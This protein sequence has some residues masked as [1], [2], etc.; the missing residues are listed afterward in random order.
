MTC[1]NDKHFIMNF[2]GNDVWKTFDSLRG[3]RPAWN[4]FN[5]PLGYKPSFCVYL[6]T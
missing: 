4:G 6:K 3:V 2:K 1:C 5:A